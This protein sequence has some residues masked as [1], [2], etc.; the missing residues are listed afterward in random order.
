MAWS[1]ASSQSSSAH[2]RRCTLNLQ[3]LQTCRVSHQSKRATARLTI[4][5]TASCHTTSLS[6]ASSQPSSAHRRG[7]CLAL[8]RHRSHALGDGVSCR[9]RPRLQSDLEHLHRRKAS[10]NLKVCVCVCVLPV[11]PWLQSVLEHVHSH[12]ASE[13]CKRVHVHTCVFFCVCVCVF[14]RLYLGCSVF[15]STCTATKQARVVS[16][17]MCIRVHVCV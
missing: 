17:C 4:N 15:L 14:N 13:D 5:F 8:S 2:K 11:V 3:S 1:L 6:L 10:N 9:P 7:R 12:K 16:M